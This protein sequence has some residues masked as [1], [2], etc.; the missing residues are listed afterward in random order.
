MEQG[1]MKH[2]VFT[3]FLFLGSAGCSQ[4]SDLPE[5]RSSQPVNWTA[6]YSG[7]AC[8]ELTSQIMPIEGVSP[9][10]SLKNIEFGLEFYLPQGMGA[11]DGDYPFAVPGNRFELKGYPYYQLI[12]G[13]K[14]L[15]PR[16]DLIAWRIL[17]PY[18]I[19]DEQG[20][21]KVITDPFEDYWELPPEGNSSYTL[22]HK[23]DN[24]CL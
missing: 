7:W 23:Y 21:P 24:G 15:S 11:P 4:Q 19:Y 12:D 13:E 10:F 6:W 2:I 8:G 1:R 5:I 3:L 20:E 17:P 16:F 22:A 18:R 9:S 14:V